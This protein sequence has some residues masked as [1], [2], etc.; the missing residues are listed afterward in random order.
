M[1][2][3][4]FDWFSNSYESPKLYKQLITFWNLWNWHRITDIENNR[5]VTGMENGYLASRRNLSD[6]PD[7]HSPSTSPTYYSIYHVTFTR[8]VEMFLKDLVFEYFGK[9]HAR[10]KTLWRHVMQ[11]AKASFHRVNRHRNRVTRYKCKT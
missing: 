1:D 8:F 10:T 9:H 3:M 4:A 6:V 2:M 11:S 5:L 7:N